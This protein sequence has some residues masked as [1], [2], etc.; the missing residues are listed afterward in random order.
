MIQN[1][2][3]YFMYAIEYEIQ[4]CKNNRYQKIEKY[5]DFGNL[6]TIKTIQNFNRK[7]KPSGE[8]DKY[9]SMYS[10]GYVEVGQVFS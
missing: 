9:K 1:N 6:K 5:Y 8:L 2:R 4:S 10:Q 7:R 3:K